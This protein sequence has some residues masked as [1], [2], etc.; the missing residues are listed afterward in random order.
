L[1]EGDGNKAPEDQRTQRDETATKDKERDASTGQRDAKHNTPQHSHRQ[2]A[3]TSPSASAENPAVAPA[4]IWTRACT[5]ASHA[6]RP[7]TCRATLP[8]TLTTPVHAADEA[9][10]REKVANVLL[11]PLGPRPRTPR[12]KGLR[13]E[14]W[15]EPTSSSRSDWPSAP[16][17][18]DM[19]ARR[20][21]FTGVYLATTGHEKTQQ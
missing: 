1:G 9:N 3:S 2:L 11:V 6:P 15:K 10:G 8:R 17:I 12:P 7:A 14:F 4:W 13:V 21:G 18:Q 20:G 5:V 19:A 16:C